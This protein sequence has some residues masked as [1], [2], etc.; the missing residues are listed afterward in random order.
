MKDTAVLPNPK[1]ATCSDHGKPLELFCGRCNS[2]ICVNC[3]Y[4]KHKHHTISCDLITDCYTKQC[5]ELRKRLSPVERKKEALKNV[6]SALA[7]REGEIRERGEG[8]LKEIHEMVEEMINVLC[9]SER[10]L[11]EQ[12]K[13]VT[14]AKLKVLSEQ[15][16][17][18]EKSSGRLDKV[19]DYVEQR[20]KTDSPQQ[21]LK[22]KKQIM[23]RMSKVTAQINLEKLHPKE[24]ADF[25]LSKD[26]KSLHHIG[27]I[28][29]CSSSAL[30]Q[31]RVKKVGCFEH[32]LK[33]KKILLSLLMESPDSSLV[34]SPLFSQV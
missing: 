34:C 9:Q 27:D 21:V 30:Q 24:K 1:E 13:R 26:I 7:E 23:E 10:K 19:K 32:L 6:M 16:K 33:E 4:C 14:D 12:A 29:A 8:I 25:V 20:L 15:M 28:V 22:S 31:C 17:S 11:T 2:V 18:A 5:E 3:L